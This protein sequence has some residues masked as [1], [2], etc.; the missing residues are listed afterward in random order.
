MQKEINTIIHSILLKDTA[1]AVTPKHLLNFSKQ[2]LHKKHPAK[3]IHAFLEIGHLPQV[4]A[5]F[6]YSKLQKKWLNTLSDLIIKS[7]YHTGILIRQRAKRYSEHILF[8]TINGN[9]I[10]KV[11][12]QEAWGKIK[13][14][15]SSILKMIDKTDQPVI[16]LYTPNLLESALVDL[17][18]L[19]FHIKIVPIPANTSKEHLKYIVKHARITHLFVGGAEQVNHIEAIPNKFSSILIVLLPKAPSININHI[20]WKD[21][22]QNI[23]ESDKKLLN[24]RMQ[25]TTMNDDTT[26][27]YTSGTTASPKGIIFTQTNI[28]TK[29]F[30]RA[31]ALPDINSNDTFLCYLPLYHTFGRYLEM[32][33]TIFWGATYT[34]A[35]SPSFKSLLKNMQIT[36][37][38]IFISI[39]KRWFQLYELFIS[40]SSVSDSSRDKISLLIKD[41]T[42]GKLRLGL[43]AAGYLDPDI[44]KFFHNHNIQLLSGY[45]MTEATGGITMTQPNNYSEESVGVPLP[46]IELKLSNDNELLLKGPYVISYYHGKN[47]KSALVDGWFHTGDIFE[48]K[49]DHYYIIDRKK[50]IYKNSRGLTISPQ[51]IENMFQDFDAVRSVFLV[52]DGKAYNTVLLYPDKEWVKNLEND[53]NFILQDYYSSLLQSVNSFLAPFER[54]VNFAIIDRDFSTEKGELTPKKT[55]KRKTILNNFTEH[56]SPMYEKDFNFFLHD[57]N[58]VR[59]PKWLLRKA[60]IIA[61]ELKWDGNILS[62]RDTK[63]SLELK[64]YKSVVTIGDY[65]YKNLNNLLD[66]NKLVVSPELWLGNH[67]FVE[68]FTFS[69]IAPKHFEQPSDITF[70]LPSFRFNS[71]SVDKKSIDD[72]KCALREKVFDL[73]TI[74][75]SVIILYNEYDYNLST[76]IN[77]LSKILIS[78]KQNLVEIAITLLTRLR[79]HPSFKTRVKAVEVLT[80]YIDGELF[81]KLLSEIYLNSEDAKFLK[82]IT[83]DIRVLKEDHFKCI[84]NKLAYLRHDIGDANQQQLSFIEALLNTITDYGIE[85]PTDYQWARLELVKWNLSS[86]PDNIIAL[87]SSAIDN[88]ISGFRKWLGPN[89]Y[90]AIDQESGEEYSW[91]ETIVFDPN[92]AD[93]YKES[94]FDAIS[95]TQLLKE[96]IF[97]LSKRYIVQLDDIQLR[98]VWVMFLGRNHGK[99]VFRVTTQTR[100]HNNYNFVINLNEEQSNEFIKNEIKWLITTGSSSR[101]RKLVEDFGGYW[102]EYKIF[103][104]EYVQ[105]ETL[106]QYLERNRYQI[107]SQE[108]S[109]LWQL[110]WLHFIL[111]GTMA[112][113]S[114]Y[115]RS[116]FKYYIANSSS[117]N[118]II[119]E[120]DYAI[121]TRLISI[122][123]RAPIN[124]ITSMF[125]SLYEDFIIDSENRY[126]GLQHVAD[127]EVLFCAFLQTIS[128]KKGIEQLEILIGELDR[129]TCQEKA[130]KYNLTRNRIQKFIYDINENGLLTKQVIFAS[131]RYDRW[132]N[133]NPNATIEARGST[134]QQLYNDYNLVSLVDDYP[135]TRIRFF[136]M[137]AFK[138][139]NQSI[140]NELLNLQKGLRAKTILVEN[141]D[142]HI[143]E[144]NKKIKLSHDNEYFITRLIFEHIAADGIGKNFVW[145]SGSEG[146][147]ELISAT[148]DN[149]G[150]NH[151]IRQPAH[152]KEI[153]RFQTLLLNSNLTAVFNQQHEFLFIINSTNQLIG[154][155][156]WIKTDDKC[157]FLERIVIHPKYRKRYLSNILLDELFN[158]LK[159]KRYK[160]ITVGY[161]Q[162][163]LFYNKGFHIDKRFGG[164]V[165]KLD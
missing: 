141:L 77:Y 32:M 23:S 18:C 25:L 129:E 76:A 19:S 21:F 143:N 5:M 121:G 90:I 122:S 110:R 103:T 142:E 155:V 108:N 16:G 31:L 10:S 86:A 93:R 165:K 47:K 45:G 79:F 17:A 30:S 104:E 7:K 102:P 146:K 66:L 58:E 97:L 157:A 154:G 67:Q 140:K 149:F 46:G 72:L 83:L 120:R 101:G 62:I 113:F 125:I 153:A 68:F 33:G 48:E 60:G 111:N 128:I 6:H 105:G 82:D 147:L 1:Q 99:S 135:E 159:N 70:D 119:P 98:G 4:N 126:T 100:D 38:S 13:M 12:Y 24:K 152:P 133:L 61:N 139:S 52:G 49:N 91:K 156:Y 22:I 40:D 43:S 9:K 78:D 34:F 94:L 112:Y 56:I 8:Q 107:D 28:I 114:F 116:N 92:V 127:W 158:R 41:T 109:D 11:S 65:S 74:H 73:E 88:L 164:L 161:F 95:K 148:T 138:D 3:L 123:S 117:K 54:I 35:E 162:A 130:K 136:I 144:I 118:L 124:T 63:K 51:K 96:A 151:Q 29:R 134:I 131:L 36:K 57:D 115:R 106:Y 27:M 55:Y 2:L 26:I 53:E 69:A 71:I 59:I 160:Y 42:G 137:T 15:G 163:G 87:T 132:L 85:H 64:F 37:P 84:L 80:P 75:N 145:D 150:E 20:L 50:E 81:I 14:V 39:P 89:R 44:F